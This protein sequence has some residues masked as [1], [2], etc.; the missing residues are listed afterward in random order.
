MSTMEWSAVWGRIESRDGQIK[1]FP[2]IELSGPNIGQPIFTLARSNVYFEAGE[3]SFEVKTTNAQSGCQLI[4]NDTSVEQYFVGL[5]TVPTQL[6]VVMKFSQN[7]WEPMVS[8]GYGDILPLDTWLKIRIRVQGSQIDLFVNDILMCKVYVRIV[9]SP[10]SFYFFGA[11]EV[12]VR[13]IVIKARKPTA[14]IVMEFTEEFN[15]LYS[16]VIKP[17]CESFGYECIR[18]DDQYSGGLIIEDIIRSLRDASVIIADITPNNLNVF[19]EVGFAHGISKPTILL[20]NKKREKLPF[21]LSGFRTLFYD[22]TI[23]GKGQ[24]EDKLRKH[25]QGIVFSV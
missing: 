22:N 17:T 7:K 3:I 18:A 23:A 25:L 14:F 11:Q 20:S 8:A 6:Y 9:R 10:L 12:M 16:E 1:Y 21:D 13:N 5:S 24:I 19:Y 4:L 15:E 2:T